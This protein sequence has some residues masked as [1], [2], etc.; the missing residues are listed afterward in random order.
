MPF[1]IRP[2]THQLPKTAAL[3]VQFP[4][5][6]RVFL[7]KY[8]PPQDRIFAFAGTILGSPEIH[9]AGGCA[10]RFVMDVDKIDDIRS[11]Y[12]GPH[13]VMYCGTAMEARRIK[14]FAK[15]AKLEFVGNV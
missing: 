13:P 10:S 14:A 5:G 2:F 1:R 15:L 8:I 11:I 6:E 3:D 7:M 4:P 12:Q 9:T